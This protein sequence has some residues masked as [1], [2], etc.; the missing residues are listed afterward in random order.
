MMYWFSD[1]KSDGFNNF[2]L[3]D[4]MRLLK[5]ALFCV[6]FLFF[7]LLGNNKLNET[8]TSGGTE[9][10]MHRIDCGLT[11]LCETNFLGLLVEDL[12][13]FIENYYLNPI[14]TAWA[15]YFINDGEIILSIHK[16]TGSE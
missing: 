5:V 11:S 4:V 16:D 6:L 2:F 8:V 15:F 7:L 10:A 12:T 13:L 9:C 3:V 1:I 14:M